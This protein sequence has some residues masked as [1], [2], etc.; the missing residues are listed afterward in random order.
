MGDEASNCNM[1]REPDH[2]QLFIIRLWKEDTPTSALEYRG[3]VQHAL[4]GEVRHFRDWATLI[5]FLVALFEQGE[6]ADK[7]HDWI[8]LQTVLNCI[9]NKGV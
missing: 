3:R 5:E 6:E 1:T 2:S 8:D 9:H 4:S 7:D